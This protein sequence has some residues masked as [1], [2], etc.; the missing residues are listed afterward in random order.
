[1]GAEE[2]INRLEIVYLNFGYLIVFLSALV[3]ISPFGWTIP[4]GLIIAGGGFYSFS[5]R[6]SFL[7]ILVAS[8]LGSWL[9][10]LGAYLLGN[11]TGMWL[12]KKLR[13]E[14]NARRSEILLK[15]HGGVI[16]TTSMMA[17]LTRFWVAYVAGSQRYNA[18]KFVF[19][20][21]AA[22]LTWSSLMASVGYLA[23]SGRAKLEIGIARLGILGWVL[24]LVA[25]G[26]IYWKTQ[27][28]FKTLEGEEK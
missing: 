28:E 27:K 6:I 3:E 24:L 4:G 16:L 21:G 23:G 13:Q 19:Y 10:F 2:I 17:N 15:K 5:G 22:S 7:T 11:K 14:K 20:S 26:I 8:W 1:M 18:L 12:V 9:T 25:L